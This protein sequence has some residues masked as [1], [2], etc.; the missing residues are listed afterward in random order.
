MFARE[1][2]DCI[3]DPVHDDAKP[4]NGRTVIVTDDSDAHGKS[5]ACKKA[6][7]DSPSSR[8][9]PSHGEVAERL[10]APHC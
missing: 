9:L 4:T 6:M 7:Q 3:H 10:K 5:I 1:T 2:M 8:I